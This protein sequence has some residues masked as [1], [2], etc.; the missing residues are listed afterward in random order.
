MECLFQKYGWSRGVL[1]KYVTSGVYKGYYQVRH[2]PEAEAPE[3]LDRQS[4]H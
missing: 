2:L 4:I 1:T 3:P